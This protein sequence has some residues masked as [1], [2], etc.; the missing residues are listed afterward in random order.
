MSL[1][2]ASLLRLM[3]Q[4]S[5]R[6]FTTADLIAISGMAPAAATKALTR[7]SSQGLT[8]RIKKGVWVS[9]LAEGLNPYEAVPFLRAPW[10]AYVSLHS[11]LADCGVVEEIPQVVYGV[12]P[13]APKRYRTPIGEFHFHHL[14]ARLM[15]GYDVRRQGLAGFSAAEPEKAFLDLVYLALVP[16]CPLA[17]P[18]KRGR[19]WNLD[20]PKLRRYA[21]RFGFPPLDRWLV[22]NRLI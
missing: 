12:S 1:S 14:P 16:R 3:H 13:A 19:K 18:V 7:L 20:V 10:P 9:K 6:V 22:E 21:G 17:F 4:H 5:M 8:A 15:W 11:V 2:A